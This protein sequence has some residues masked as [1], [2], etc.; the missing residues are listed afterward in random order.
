MRCHFCNLWSRSRWRDR[1]IWFDVS[2]AAADN[3]CL[4]IVGGLRRRTSMEDSISAT[5][6]LLMM[7]PSTLLVR[8]RGL[9]S[10]TLLSSF[11]VV[12]AR[13]MVYLLDQ[14]YYQEKG[15]GNKLAFATS[16]L[17]VIAISG[18]LDV[19]KKERLLD[20]CLLE[21]VEDRLLILPTRYFEC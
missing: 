17:V 3:G 18:K 11:S 5:P 1:D 15:N 6:A 20:T 7:L 13:I 8:N 9:L 14:M 19:T 10:N 12:P 21:D 4:I 16:G 2:I